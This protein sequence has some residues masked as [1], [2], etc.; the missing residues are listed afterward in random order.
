MGAFWLLFG[1]VGR[2]L[3]PFKSLVNTDVFRHFRY[4]GSSWALLGL[5]WSLLCLLGGR[6]GGLGD[7]YERLLASSGAPL[8]SLRALLDGVLGLLGRS[9]SPKMQKCSAGGPGM[10]LGCHW[11]AFG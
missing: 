2:T 1:G 5:P 8:G 3:G 10:P 7:S 9:F 6:L 11:G 4:L